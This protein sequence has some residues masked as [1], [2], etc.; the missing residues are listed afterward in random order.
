MVQ[1]FNLVSSMKLQLDPSW[2]QI[3]CTV[4]P[5]ES[6]VH[7]ATKTL[8]DKTASNRVILLLQIKDFNI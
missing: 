3:L 6:H 1:W 2:E 5:S 8:A 4:R 7:A